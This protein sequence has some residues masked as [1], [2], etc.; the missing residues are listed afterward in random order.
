M[1]K[2]S[3]I[4][5][6]KKG[7]QIAAGKLADDMVKRLQVLEPKSPLMNVALQTIG[8]TLQ[9]R[10]IMNATQ[11]RI[12]D[13]GALRASLRYAVNGST[14]TAG[15]FGVRYARVHEK[16]R[17]MKPNEVRAMFANMAK[18]SRKPRHGGVGGKG[19]F[20]GNAQ[21]GGKI[22]ARPFVTI[23]LKQ[24]QARIRAILAQYL[25]SV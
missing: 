1:A 4:T 15:S 6:S 10:M 9:N 21:K 14:V 12:I 22:K 8:V 23:A 16:G 17:I 24:E 7:R 18:R 25:A 5:I 3:G 11:Q 13:T 20:S 2:K 19:V